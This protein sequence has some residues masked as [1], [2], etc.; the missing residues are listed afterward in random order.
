MIAA[1]NP[2]TWDVEIAALFIVLGEIIGHLNT[3]ELLEGIQQAGRDAKMD[4][5]VN[6]EN[7]RQAT[8]KV[9][10]TLLEGEI[11]LSITP[12]SKLDYRK[13]KEVFQSIVS[14]ISLKD[15]DLFDEGIQHA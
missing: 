15:F 9:I 13:L 2:P 12:F 11:L 3:K 5:V 4:I 1:Y 8:T 7:L 10:Y 14:E 6:F